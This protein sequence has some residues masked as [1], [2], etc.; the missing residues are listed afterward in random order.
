MHTKGK[1]PVLTMHPSPAA[2]GH[3]CKPRSPVS[4]VSVGDDCNKQQPELVRP[5][6]SSDTGIPGAFSGCWARLSLLIAFVCLLVTMARFDLEEL[7]L[8]SSRELE[9]QPKD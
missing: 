5:S 9:R 1:G 2:V 4:C 8:P 6:V 3:N 7:E